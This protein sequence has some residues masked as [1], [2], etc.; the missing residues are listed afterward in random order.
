MLLAG[1]DALLALACLWAGWMLL[2]TRG[3]GGAAFLAVAILALA[4]PSAAGAARFGGVEGDW[5]LALHQGASDLYALLGFAAVAVALFLVRDA[6]RWPLV[7]GLAMMLVAGM[8]LAGQVALVGPLASLFILAGTV[9]LM[10]RG[11]GRFWLALSMAGVVCA[12]LTRVPGLLDPDTR[13][14]GLHLALALWVAALAVGVRG[15][16]SSSAR[17][18]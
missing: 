5:L 1:S 10:R 4:I 2:T 12:A 9:C 15:H 7:A 18:A 13:I 17:M 8:A 16:S 6:R 11:P 3:A 14:I